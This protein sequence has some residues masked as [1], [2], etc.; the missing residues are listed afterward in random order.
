MQQRIEWMKAKYLFSI[1]YKTGCLFLL[2]IKNL[3]VILNL[4]V[5]YCI[6]LS[7]TLSVAGVTASASESTEYGIRKN[8]FNVN[9]KMMKIDNHERNRI[10]PNFRLIR[11]MQQLKPLSFSNDSF[12]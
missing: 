2:F 5:D 6:A 1:W 7:I 10:K 8:A 12:E 4:V 3:V 11:L 9:E